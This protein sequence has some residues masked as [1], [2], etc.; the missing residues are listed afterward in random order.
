MEFA[1]QSV[2]QA[3][4]SES[5]LDEMVE[6]LACSPTELMLLDNHSFD[7]HTKIHL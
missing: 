1:L 4:T 7:K 3:M 2:H 5:D 6:K